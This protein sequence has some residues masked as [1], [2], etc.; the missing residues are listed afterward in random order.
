MEP[1]REVQSASNEP[2]SFL[3][4][5]L[6]YWERRR[7]F[8][9][10][11]L[12]GVVMVWIAQNLASFPSRV[13]PAISPVAD[14]T[15]VGGQCLL[16]RR[17]SRGYSRAGLVFYSCMVATRTHGLVAGGNAFGCRA[18]QLLDRGRDLPVRALM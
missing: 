7:I 18:G 16:L 6:R 4:N 2:R 9:N 13:Q 1:Q 14:R 10:V 12:T 15:D 11:A 17:V 5:A 3:R 8:Y